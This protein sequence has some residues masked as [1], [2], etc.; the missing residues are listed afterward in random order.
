MDKKQGNFIELHIEKVVLVIAA[1]LAIYIVYAFVL[2]GPTPPTINGQKVGLGQLDIY[3][4]EQADKLKDRL[5][6]EPI[7]KPPYVPKSINFI[8]MMNHVI[9]SNL[10]VVWPM[11]GSVESS[12]SKKYRIPVIGDVNGVDVEH[13]RAAAYLPKV[14]LDPENALVDES[15][16]VNDLDLVTVQGT[17]DLAAVIDSFQECFTGKEVPEGSRDAGLAKPVFAGVQLQRQRLSDDGQWSDW[18]TVPRVKIDPERDKYKIIDNLNELPNGGVMVEIARFSGKKTQIDLLQPASYVIASAEE[19][20]LPPTLHR[21]YV[22]VRREKE[23]QDRREAILAERETKATEDRTARPAREERQSV[24]R[25]TTRSTSGR[26]TSSRGPGGLERGPGSMDRTPGASDRSGGASRT[27]SRTA[28]RNERTSERDRRNETAA[29][30]TKKTAKPTVTEVTINDEFKKI[31]L[32]RKDISTLHETITFWAYDDT[33]EPGASYRYRIRLGVFNPLAGSDQV[34]EQDEANKN[35]VVLWSGYSEVTDIVDIPK[36]MYFF[37]LNVQETAKAVEVQVCRYVLGYWH[38]EQFMVKRGDMIGKTAKVETS[39]KDKI[40]GLKMP[41][42]I[43]YTTGS[44]LVDM[45]PV[46]D[47]TGEKT[48]QQRQY[49]DVL[50]SADG[51]SIDRLPAKQMYWPED[52]SLKFSELKAL[53]KK[54][55]E[56]FRARSEGGTMDIVPRTG[57]PRDRRGLERGDE[58]QMDRN[59]DRNPMDRNPGQ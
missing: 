21:K 14:A 36:R 47:W 53:E 25:T 8:E 26:S 55:K 20:W 50:F 31:Q 58:M 7:L 38:S 39:D 9:D 10:T 27:T 57:M 16:E 51:V 22:A 3:I 41:E 24:E 6:R 5:D 1:L 15:Y 4:A 34:K 28:T 45:V 42:S 11:P 35:K 49:F 44:I 54:A 37:P 43:D 29:A 23:A 17:F 59:P 40:A 52:L 19:R 12:I 13:I 18:E 48:L 32:A 33:V 30:E 56:P 2:V 46:N